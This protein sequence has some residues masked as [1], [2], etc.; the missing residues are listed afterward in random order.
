M[1]QPGTQPLPPPPAPVPMGLGLIDVH[2]DNAGSF[3]NYPGASGIF[4]GGA[5]TAANTSPPD[6]IPDDDPGRII[7]R[8]TPIPNVPYAGRSDVASGAGTFGGILPGSGGI[9]SIAN[10]F[11]VYGNSVPYQGGVFDSSR[12]FG[13]G[14]AGAAQVESF[15]IAW[16]FSGGM[17]NGLGGNPL[18]VT[19][20]MI[21]P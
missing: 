8:G 13:V 16:L 19:T 6:I 7:V 21:K 11:D 4:T 20:P 10:Y 1:P 5:G 12:G 9:D 2:L 15:D 18:D 3:S 17:M 14:T